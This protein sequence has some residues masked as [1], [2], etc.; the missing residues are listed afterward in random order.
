M[1]ILEAAARLRS[2]S[3]SSVEMTK[4]ALASAER[5][6]PTLNAFITITGDEAL[7]KARRA[8]DEMAAGRDAGPL[9]GIPIALKDLFYTR[10]VRTTGG[11]KLFEHFVPDHD[12]AVV[13][14]LEA[15]GAISIG[16][17]NLHE[18]AYGITSANPHFGPVCNPWKLDHSPGGSSGGSGAVVATGIVSAAMGTDTGG[19]IR[20]PASFCGTVGLK[21]TYGRVSRF[22]VMPLGWSLDHMGPL[23]RTV[24]DAAIVLDAIAG[25]D[26][27]DPASSRKPV[28][29]S[30]PEQGCGIRG[31]KIGIPENYYF[32]RVEPGVESAVRAAVSLAQMSGAEIRPVRVPDIDGLNAAARVI[33]LAEAS[34]S[35]EPHLAKRDHFGAD[36]LALLDQGRLLSATDYIHAQRLRHRIRWE[37]DSV[38]SSVDC[39]LTPTTPNTAPKI[40]QKTV[41]F[42]ERDEDVRLATTRL[43]RGVNVLGFPALSIPCG[44]TEGLPV[45]LQ[46]IAAPFREAAVLQLGAALEDAGLGI[47]PSPI[48]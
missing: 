1:T 7:R 45:G 43:L 12:A 9:H 46:I 31:W 26:K 8:D 11:S 38:W 17:L 37:F 34:A 28:T 21:P 29:P 5:L 6:N 39:V 30:V 14:R 16:K 36:V 3:V 22:G 2:R 40:G 44:I 47:P 13:E 41:R 19:S 20:I 10:G 42:G 15:A 23:T 33:L 32:D 48:S 18:C 27:R 35:L 4:A 25:F 24:R